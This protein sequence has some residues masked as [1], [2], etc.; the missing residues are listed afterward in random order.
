[1]NEQDKN[2]IYFVCSIIE[3][4]GRKTKNRR[5]DIV[6]LLGKKEIKRQLELAEVNHSLSIEQ[7]TDELI[8]EFHITEGAYDSVGNSK[9]NIPSVSGIAKNYQRLIIGDLKAGKEILDA[10]YDVFQS[11]ISDDISDFNSSVYYSSPEYLRLSYE[12]GK[13]LK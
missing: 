8:E 6:R 1:M 7:V 10:F 3:Y 13:L 4:L 5:S 9:Y 11:F 12:E 2:N